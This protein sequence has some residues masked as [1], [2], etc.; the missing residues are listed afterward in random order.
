MKTKSS[1]F[2]RDVGICGLAALL[3]VGVGLAVGRH[4]TPP[5]TEAS[6]IAPLS[7]AEFRAAVDGGQ[8]LVIDARGDIP[9]ARGHVP[10]ALS[11]PYQ[12]FAVRYRE[13]KSQLEA[14]RARPI[15]LYCG[16]T[17]CDA[18]A[19]LQARLR[20]LGYTNVAVFPHGWTAWQAA[21]YPEEK[22]GAATV[23]LAPW[24]NPS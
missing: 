6:T 24:K 5:P 16:N 10:R 7:L 2:L 19:K 22:S 12:R 1:T 9:Y 21:G 11:L 20:A 8:A 18:S 4:Q 14:D 17:D 3:S 23:V 15:I 13:L